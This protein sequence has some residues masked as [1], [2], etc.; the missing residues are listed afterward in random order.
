MYIAASEGYIDIIKYFINKNVNIDSIDDRL[1]PCTPLNIACIFNKISVVDLLL[2]HGANFE[3]KDE[4]GRTAL[5]NA[6]LKGNT[7]IVKL[8]L[9]YGANKNVKDKR[10]RMI[11]DV[12]RPKIKKEIIELLGL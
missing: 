12:K 5:F 7:E 8:L 11:K 9:E 2:Q 4:N 3:A 1:Q 6:A 10:G